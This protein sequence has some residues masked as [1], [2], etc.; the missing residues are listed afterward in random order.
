MMC[1]LMGREGTISGDTDG[2]GTCGGEGSFSFYPAFFTHTHTH[3]HTR[4][5]A[6][7]RTHAHTHTHGRAHT[8]TQSNTLH[9][10]VQQVSHYQTVVLF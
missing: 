10:F 8:H 5:H 7:A 9:N 4:T 2:K 6:R 1:T 3:T